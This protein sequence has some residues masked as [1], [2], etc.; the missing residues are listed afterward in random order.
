MPRMPSTR[1]GHRRP[2]PPTP[3]RV[4]RFPFR[5]L[6]C[7]L[8]A[9][10]GLGLTACAREGGQATDATPSPTTSPASSE[11]PGGTGTDGTGGSVS[12]NASW[13]GAGAPAGF[14]RIASSKLSIAVPADFTIVNDP[15]RLGTTDLAATSETDGEGVRTVISAR[16]IP[17]PDGEAVPEEG[18]A[19][20]AAADVARAAEEQ[21]KSTDVEIVDSD[22]AQQDGWTVT[23]TS[24]KSAEAPR[25]EHLWMLVDVDDTSF[26]IV[27]IQGRP[28]SF[29]SGALA[30]VPGTLVIRGVTDGTSPSP[31]AP[32]P[33]EETG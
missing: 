26:A 23:W 8:V 21:Q 20:A 18:P 11:S 25:L 9:A 30:D 22:V 1:P 10:L 16:V 3:A 28:E 14:H 7:A 13:A 29:A 12:D 19:W 24:P 33:T 32:S 31:T 2:F 5:S 6:T 27:S 4:R 15:Q 17:I